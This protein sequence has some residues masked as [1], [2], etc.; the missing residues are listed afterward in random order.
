MINEIK[1]RLEDGGDVYIELIG[2]NG[3]R[4]RGDFQ[5]SLIQDLLDSGKLQV[6]DVGVGALDNIVKVGLYSSCRATFID[7]EDLLFFEIAPESA[8]VTQR[9]TNN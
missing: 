7:E 5:E 8:T 4:D 9:K 2:P 3:L 6:L 1:R